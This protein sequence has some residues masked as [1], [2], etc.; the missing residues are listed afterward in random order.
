MAS[1]YRYVV[2]CDLLFPN[3]CVQFIVAL[4]LD[5]PEEIRSFSIQV[6]T[7]NGWIGP[8]P[9]SSRVNGNFTKLAILQGALLTFISFHGSY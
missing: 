2:V 3:K 8:R 4:V 9:E 5:T 7:V 6:S 1:G